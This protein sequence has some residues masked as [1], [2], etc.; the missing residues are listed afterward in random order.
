[1]SSNECKETFWGKAYVLDNG[2]TFNG[3]SRRRMSLTGIRH[4]SS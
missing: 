3:L 2:G 1:M 4:L